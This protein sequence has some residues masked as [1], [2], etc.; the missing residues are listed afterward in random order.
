MADSFLRPAA[1]PI[2][3]WRYWRFTAGSGRLT[4]VTQRGF[5]WEV[6]RPLVARCVGGGHPAPDVGCNCGIH[7]SA[8]LAGLRDH[9]LCLAPGALVVGEV[10]LWGRVVLDDHG[11]RGEVAAPRRLWLVGDDPAVLDPLGAYG[12]PVATMA[13]SEALG[14]MSA[15]TMAFLAMS[16]PRP[17]GS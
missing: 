17:A 10:A 11:Y 3:G 16:G 6:E 8:D 9:A 14:E 13:A 15:T 1:E 5:T 4:S 12:V 7:A 2:V